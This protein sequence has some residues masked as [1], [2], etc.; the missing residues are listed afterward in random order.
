MAHVTPQEL[1]LPKKAG[2]VISGQCNNR[3]VAQAVANSSKPES[4]CKKAHWTLKDSN[5]SECCVPAC[6]LDQIRMY[7]SLCKGLKSVYKKTYSEAESI[8]DKVDQG[9]QIS[10]G[11]S[12]LRGM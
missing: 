10:K 2:H 11:R 7:I 4:G 12:R 5:T 9:K 6:V 3:S 1:G 8:A